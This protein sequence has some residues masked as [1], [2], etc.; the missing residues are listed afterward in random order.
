VITYVDA[1]DNETLY[2][3]LA[4]KL[5]ASTPIADRIRM[6]QV[7]LAT[8]YLGQGVPFV[9]A[10]SEILRSKSLDR[11][12]YN[13]GDWFN[14]LDFTYRSNGFGSGLPPAADNGAKWTYARPLLGSAGLRPSSGDI[15]ASRD[16]TADW[17]RIRAS[18][19]LFNLGTAALV[20]QKVSFPHGGPG[21]PVGLV[22]MRIDDT[23][24]P[25]TDPRLAGLVVVFNA[26]GTSQTI[27][28]PGLAGHR[29][30]L[31]P[32]QAGGF[33]PVVR[34]ARATGGVLTVPAR[35]V[36]VFTD[37]G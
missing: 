21:Q 11:N 10:G 36:A 12:S 35:T 26:S 23:A 20:R 28:V 33:D 31:H 30:A 9:H 27:E 7:A 17:L 13:S 2:D 25:D 18:S 24:G 19:P 15:A 37:A 14:R 5:P 8:A 16:R 6:Q 4:Y 34:G 32:V 22:V 1:H 29:L 3:A